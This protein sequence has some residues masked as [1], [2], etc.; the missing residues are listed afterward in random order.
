[1][2]VLDALRSTAD[3]FRKAGLPLPSI[4]LDAI[5]VKRLDVEIREAAAVAGDRFGLAEINWSGTAGKLF[6]IAISSS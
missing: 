2:I 4:K 1:M 5:T 6:G 3:A